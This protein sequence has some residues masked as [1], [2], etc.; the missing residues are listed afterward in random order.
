MS[1]PRNWTIVTSACGTGASKGCNAFS[2]AN[3]TKASNKYSLFAP[4]DECFADKPGGAL[5]IAEWGYEFEIFTPQAFPTSDCVNLT[6]PSYKNAPANRTE[7]FD[8]MNTYFS[9][10]AAMVQGR[11]NVSSVFQLTC[12]YQ[13]ALRL[14]SRGS[15]PV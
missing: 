2:V 8:R 5:M 11:M 3:V 13:R 10:R 12:H 6:S 1:Q 7:A 4:G 9:C 15:P 14:Y